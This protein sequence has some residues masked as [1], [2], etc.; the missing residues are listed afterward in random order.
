MSFWEIFC[1]TGKIDDYLSYRMEEMQQ[2][3]ENTDNTER[4]ECYASYNERSGSA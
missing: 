1:K 2:T 3:D 4:A